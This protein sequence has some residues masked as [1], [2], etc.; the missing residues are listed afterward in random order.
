MRY[1]I[2]GDI[3]GNLDA[4]LA[5][6]QELEADPVDRVLCVGDIVGYGS[7]PRECIQLAR[8]LFSASVAGNHDYAAVGRIPVTD[9]TEYARI[10][11]EWTRGQLTEADRQYLLEMRLAEELDGFSL[12]HGSFYQPESFGYIFH[13]ASALVSFEYQQSPL[14]F[15][16]HTHQPVAFFKSDHIEYLWGRGSLENVGE[17]PDTKVLV[18]VGSVGQPRDR[19]PRAAYAVYDTEKKTV[20]IKSVEYDFEAAANKIRQAGL[21]SMLADRLYLGR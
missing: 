1:A 10:A 2:L 11:V 3:H 8:E 18:N 16:G 21:P 19:D 6:K 9:F 13:A 20:V 7:Q 5:V 14:A 12:V 15:N 17:D 4:F